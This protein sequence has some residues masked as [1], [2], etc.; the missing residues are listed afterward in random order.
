MIKLE[1]LPKGFEEIPKWIFSEEEI[2]PCWICQIRDY[3]LQ[4][5]EACRKNIF[6]YKPTS[7]L[8][9]KRF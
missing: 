8:K 2:N 3:C 6:V 7:I 1:D 9:K 5:N 4:V